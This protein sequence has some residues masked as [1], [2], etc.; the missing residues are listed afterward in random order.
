MPR[1]SKNTLRWLSRAVAA[2][3]VTVVVGLGPA[4][5]AQAADSSSGRPNFQL[6][7]TCGTTYTNSTYPGHGDY[8]IDMIMGSGTQVLA[9]AAGTAYRG[10]ST[11]GGDQVSI[12]HGNGW[13][14]LYLHLQGGSYQFCD[15]QYVR[16][17]QFVARSDNTGTS[18]SGPHL[19]FEQQLWDGSRYAPVHAY[20]NGLPSRITDDALAN[21][22]RLT[23]ANCLTRVVMS[24]EP[25]LYRV[26][27]DG[28]LLA[29]NHL[30]WASGT[31]DWSY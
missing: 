16:Q 31:G 30:G 7:Y 12:L 11:S 22:E 13:R 17:G 24:G 23:S 21:S 25:L 6:P 10:Y 28:R 1:R 20:F 14:T 3:L 18:S 4:R 27:P 15:G 9:S 8:E 19:H 5:P 26:L 2:A 29:Y